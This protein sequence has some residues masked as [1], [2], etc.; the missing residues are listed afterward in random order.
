MKIIDEQDIPENETEIGELPKEK[1]TRRRRSKLE[2]PVKIDTLNASLSGSFNGL[3]ILSKSQT[4]FDDQDFGESSKKIID[5]INLFPFL[6][7]I[8]H[9]LGPLTVLVDFV[10]KFDA[11]QNGRKPKEGANKVTIEYTPKANTPA[12]KGP[13]G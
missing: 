5:F 12:Q 13:F 11:I 8:I 10:K 3:A 6:R 7:I 1:P 9:I 4:R 2:A